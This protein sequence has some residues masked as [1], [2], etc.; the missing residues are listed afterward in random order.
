MSADPGKVHVTIFRDVAAARLAVAEWT[1]DELADK[2]GQLKTYPSKKDLPLIKLARFGEQ[3]SASG[4]LRHDGNVVAIS[5]IEADYDGGKVSLAEA[6]QMLHEHNISAVLYTTPSHGEDRPRWRV[7]C[8]TSQPYPPNERTRLVAR[9]NGALGGILAPE[10]FALSQSYYIGKVEGVPYSHARVRGQF[11]DLLPELDAKA[12][13]APKN[14]ESK[15]ERLEKIRATDGIMARLAER[16]MVLNQRTDGGADIVCPF[17]HEHTTPR[18]PADCSYWPPNTGGFTQGHFKC[19]HGHCTRRSDADFLKAIGLAAETHVQ[20]SDEWPEP[21]ELIRTSE[22]Q[23][24]PLDALP[25]IIGGAVSEVLAF[26][27]CPPAMAAMSALSVVSLAGQALAD[28]RRAPKLKGPTSLYLLAIADSGERKSTCDDFFFKAV[29]EW[30]QQSAE[31]VRPERQEYEAA[32]AAWQAKREG[33]VAAIKRAAGKPTGTLEE[34][35]RALERQKPKPPR[36]PRVKHVDTTPE[37]LAWN[38]SKPTAW[39]SAGVLSSEAGIVF[40]GHGMGRESI[41]RNLALLNILWDGGAL[42]VDRRTS[43]SFTLAGA[44]LTMGLAVQPDAVRAFF[45]NSNG[46]ARGSGFAARFLIAWPQSTQGS[47]TFTAGPERWPHLASYH[48][49][50]SALLQQAPAINDRGELEPRTLELSAEARTVWVQFY[51]HVESE[52][53][54]GGEMAET[55]D[56]ASKAAD[57][58]ARLATLFHVFEN[59]P[60]GD[61]SDDHMRAACRI[62]AWHL[63]E[64][65]RFFGEIA[66]PADLSNA[67]KL[68]TWLI[69][70]C[71]E[72]GTASVSTRTIRR[73]GPA[74]IRAGKA[75]DEAIRELEEAGR[76]RLMRDGLRKLVTLNPM[77]LWGR[78]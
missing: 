1:P 68:D 21:Q 7:L 50:I 76:L 40:G 14:G 62:V 66:L 75:C 54:P 19:L 44:R 48:S 6:Q 20:G 17:E 67:V 16:G 13:G 35:L 24:Y 2:L 56:V 32:L 49:R 63:Y 59:G 25:G 64:A 58:A 5:G 39:P 53:R 8:P 61:I 30:E 70:Y 45:D 4:S 72:K 43:E 41:M 60:A 73:E 77:L 29:G 34:S 65:R 23:P 46:L 37:S 33:I 27:Q 36:E 12:I 31:A 22:P 74:S 38:L 9:L 52:L 18:H 10:S 71:R 26:V 57:N 3:R 78:K 42:K 69:R 15:A 55:R 51:N 47:R 11:I 28:V